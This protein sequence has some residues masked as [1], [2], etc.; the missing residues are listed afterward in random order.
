MSFVPIDK[1]KCFI[2]YFLNFQVCIFWIWYGEWIGWVWCSGVHLLNWVR[3]MNRVSVG[4]FRCFN[5]SST[6]LHV[7]LHQ[8]LSFRW[9]T[10]KY[11]NLDVGSRKQRSSNGTH[12]KKNLCFFARPAQVLSIYFQDLYKRTSRIAILTVSQENFEAWR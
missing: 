5:S 6:V 8:C 9:Y 12:T 7:L 4:C 1:L 10:P 11:A 2:N 3:R